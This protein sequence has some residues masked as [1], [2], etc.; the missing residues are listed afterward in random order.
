[1]LVPLLLLD[2]TAVDLEADV[3]FLDDDVADAGPVSGFRGWPPE[4]H[5]VLQFRAGGGYVSVPESQPSL[6]HWK[7]RADVDQLFIEGVDNFFA[8]F[9]GNLRAWSVPSERHRGED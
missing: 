8:S 4:R 6:P 2:G 3:I 9:L 5:Q 1:M 7:S